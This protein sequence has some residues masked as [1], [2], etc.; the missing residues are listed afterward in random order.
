M[1][2]TWP[3]AFRLAAL[4]AAFLVALAVFALL[5][6]GQGSPR[7]GPSQAAVAPP[8]PNASTDMVISAYQQI[9]A[10]QPRNVSAAATLG[11][12]YLQKVR[13]TG[14]PSYYVRADEVLQAGR[15]VAPGDYRILAALGTLALARHQFASGLGYGEASLRADPSADVAYPVIVDGEVEL[16]RY[17]DAARAL[18][19]FV[20]TSPTLAS[21]AR[22]SYFRELHGDLG[23]A[24]AAM[25]LAVSAGG[26]VPENVAYVQTLL[27]TL[28]FDLGHLERARHAYLTALHSFPRYVA[29]DAGLARVD[30]ARGRFSSATARY[31][32]AVARLPLP[33]YVIG[34]GETELAS[35]RVARGNHDLALVRAEERLL[36]ANG[37]NTDIDLALFE[38][39]HGSPAIAVGL[40]RRAWAEAPSVRSADALGWALTRDG[41]PAAGLGWG[42]HAL[43]LGSRDPTFLYH[44]GMSALAAGDRAAART[45]LRRA[46]A[47]NPRFNP[48]YGP[49]AERALARL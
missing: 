34:L 37:V 1:T 44:A 12:A 49:R 48:L 40:A 42:R 10:A 4:A 15:R 18:Q 16:G 6:T 43:M 8:P 46:V 7:Y 38:A 25:R 47:L 39:N 19:R 2:V 30:A 11:G 13:E 28:E 23:G 9:L 20:D 36:R 31:R 27:G 35:G 32:S 33:E 14:D 5:R 29:A 17:P 45:Y 41:R 24:V 21:Y 22:V 26:A 3:R